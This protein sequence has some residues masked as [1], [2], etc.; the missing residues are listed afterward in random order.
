[1]GF[2]IA[3]DV[4]IHN[5]KKY[6]IMTTRIHNGSFKNIIIPINDETVFDN[7]SFCH[8]TESLT[9]AA[10]IHNFVLNNANIIID[11]NDDP[12]CKKFIEDLLENRTSRFIYEYKIKGKIT[13]EDVD[14]VEDI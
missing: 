5:D 7:V 8:T 4:I 11:A 3:N 6:M 12:K 2:F 13:K 14:Y 9:E 1:M 10:S